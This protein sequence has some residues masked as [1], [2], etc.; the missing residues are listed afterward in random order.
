[1]ADYKNSLFPQKF[2]KKIPQSK[3][4]QVIGGRSTGLQGWKWIAILQN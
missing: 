3:V 4:K 1:M 2:D